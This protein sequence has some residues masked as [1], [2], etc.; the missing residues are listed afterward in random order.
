MKGV[1]VT[2][3][4]TLKESVW[5]WTQSFFSVL[6]KSAVIERCLLIGFGGWFVCFVICFCAF[7]F[8]WL[9]GFHHWA[10]FLANDLS[11]EVGKN[12]IKPLRVKSAP[13]PPEGFRL[14]VIRRYKPIVYFPSCLQQCF[15][16]TAHLFPMDVTFPQWKIYARKKNVS[17]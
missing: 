10:A 16:L 14:V 11:P 6:M 7:F 9:F 4:F 1:S 2:P 5:F 13:V 12:I 3:I 8:F 15:L 17:N